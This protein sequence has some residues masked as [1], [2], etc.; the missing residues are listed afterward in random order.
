[1][2]VPH[3]GMSGFKLRIDIQMPQKEE[4]FPQCPCC[5]D[6]HDPEGDCIDNMHNFRTGPIPELANNEPV[7]DSEYIKRVKALEEKNKK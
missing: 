5:G 6:R 4:E 1:M 2:K 7:V 3:V